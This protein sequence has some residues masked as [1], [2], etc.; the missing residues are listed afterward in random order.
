[1]IKLTRAANMD[2]IELALRSGVSKNTISRMENGN[3]VNSE[4]LFAV[5]ER[6]D[7]LDPIIEAVEEQYSLVK[8]NPQR[9]KGKVEKELS[10][11]F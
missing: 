6:L 2:Q 4:S 8:K 10:N 7:L 9:N 3:S 1:L 11:D 5:L